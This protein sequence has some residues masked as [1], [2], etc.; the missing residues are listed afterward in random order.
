M[1]YTQQGGTRSVQPSALDILADPATDIERAPSSANT[2][3]AVGSN[4]SAAVTGQSSLESYISPNTASASDPSAPDGSSAQTG[5]NDDDSPP[6]TMLS[7]E[8]PLTYAV[9]LDRATSS[10]RPFTWANCRHW[11][12]II[13]S[14]ENLGMPPVE[15][16]LSMGTTYA[17]AEDVDQTKETLRALV[18]IDKEY[19]TAMLPQ[20]DPFPAQIEKISG[21]FE[22]GK[23]IASLSPGWSKGFIE[24]QERCSRL[25]KYVSQ[26]KMGASRRTSASMWSTQAGRIPS[27]PSPNRRLI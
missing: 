1:N 26:V 25:A 2:D 24:S 27:T 23:F 22:V 20:D 6:V 13:R 18:R 7:K 3:T 14:N 15:A 8:L 17:S 11:K 10:N 9:N 16:W 5:S 21:L 12:L 19:L 4:S